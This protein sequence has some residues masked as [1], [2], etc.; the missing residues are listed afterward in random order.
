MNSWVLAIRPK[1]LPAAIAPVLIG[2]AMAFGDGAFH[3]PSALCALVAA[4]FIQIGT[5]LSNDYFDFKKG[6]DRKDRKG[7]IRVTQAGLIKPRV[8]LLVAILFFILAALASSYLIHRA[9]MAILIIAMAAIISGILY[10]A[11]PCPLG[12]LGLGEVFV[13]IFFGPVAVG[14]TYFVQTFDINWAVVVAGFAPGFLSS[15][16][17][18]V[19][20]LRD[21]DT[22]RRVGKLTL[23][24][25]FGRSFAVREYLFCI[26]AATIMPFLIFLITKDHWAM[27]LSSVVGFAAIGTVKTVMTTIDAWPL[28]RALAQTGRWLLLYSV[29]F[30]L[31]WVL[32]SR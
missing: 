19:N 32:C 23:A 17:L 8:V 5:N 21:I 13:W 2:S 14:G 12:Y 9:G 20:N 4:L 29:I 18:A 6:A 15:A 31:G 16:I 22:D 24:V 3:A 26:L 10:T 28:N 25:R 27:T 11:G 1:T 30:S 7:P